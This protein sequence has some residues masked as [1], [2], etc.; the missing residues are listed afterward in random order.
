[1]AHCIW[2]PNILTQK[3]HNNQTAFWTLPSSGMFFLGASL[4]KSGAIN[5]LLNILHFNHEKTN[6]YNSSKTCPNETSPFFRFFSLRS[7][8]YVFW[9][10]QEMH[11]RE[12]NIDWWPWSN[13]FIILH[14]DWVVI[15]E[16][17]FSVTRIYSIDLLLIDLHYLI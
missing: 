11:S 6:R 1:M 10:R 4:A 3:I 9:L 12:R 7:F 5:S 2:A 17:L 14:T 8:K 15:P 16:F 13:C